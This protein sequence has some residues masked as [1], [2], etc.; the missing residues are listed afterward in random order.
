MG[1]VPQSPSRMAFK[2]WIAH[3][4]NPRVVPTGTL[5]QPDLG[6]PSASV[7]IEDNLQ[8]LPFSGLHIHIMGCPV[9][10][11]FLIFS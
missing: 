1:G 11:C 10:F 2:N 6:G 5:V 3:W 4:M 7:M 8:L 9:L